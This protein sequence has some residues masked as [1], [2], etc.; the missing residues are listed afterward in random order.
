MSLVNLFSL[1]KK[2]VVITGSGRGIGFA[3]AKGFGQEGASVIGIDQH[4]SALDPFENTIII[5]FFKTDSIKEQLS[6]FFKT[7]PRIDVW[8]NCAGITK[9]TPSESY[10]EQDW[11][12]TLQVNLTAAF[13]CCQFGGNHMIEHHVSGSIINITSVGDCLGF[14]DNPAYCAS[15]GGLN[16]LTK[17]LAYDWGKHGIRVNNLAPG[18]THTLMNQKSWKNPESKKQRAESTF[19]NRWAEPEDMIGPAIFLASDASRY[20]TGTTLYVDG[21]WTAKGL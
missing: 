18:Y 20:V 16:Q 1:Q 3:L 7:Y 10:S 17:S 4:F 2:V 8:I 9:S 6:F 21:G 13:L 11:A 12:E 15:K 14:P 19:L 5:D